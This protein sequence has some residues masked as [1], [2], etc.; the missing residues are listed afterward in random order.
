MSGLERKVEEW[1]RYAL[2]LDAEPT[3][4]LRLPRWVGRK[5]GLTSGAPKKPSG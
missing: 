4:G 1:A 5:L 2:S 3:E